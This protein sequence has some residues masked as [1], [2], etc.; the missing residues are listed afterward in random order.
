MNGFFEKDWPGVAQICM[1]KRTVKEKGE[2]RVEIVY[3]M[4]NLPRKKADAK[5]LLQL[6]RKH[7]FVENRLHHRRDVSLREDASQIRV[8]GTPEVLAALNGGILAFM[9][10]IGVKNVAK[11]MRYFCEYPRDALQ[12][13]LCKPSRQ[14]G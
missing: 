2:E 11:Q 12:L 9:D 13:L 6:N 7:W 14:N 5:Q 3:S 1:I 4:T 8:K 10:F